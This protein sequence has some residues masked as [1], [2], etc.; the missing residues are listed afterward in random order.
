MNTGLMKNCQVID[1]KNNSLFTSILT[2]TMNVLWK[3]QLLLEARDWNFFIL[4][5]IEYFAYL[6]T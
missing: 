1:I 6:L 4:F 3:K 5:L 2:Y